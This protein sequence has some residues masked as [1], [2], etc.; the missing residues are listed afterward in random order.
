MKLKCYLSLEI[1]LSGLH[2]SCLKMHLVGSDPNQDTFFPVDMGKPL[3]LFNFHYLQHK[4]NNAF[5][6]EVFKG[7]II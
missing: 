3:N 5:R 6:R 1:Y 7:L 4:A 2:L